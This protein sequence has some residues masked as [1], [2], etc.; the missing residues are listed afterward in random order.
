[1]ALAALVAPVALGLTGVSAGAAAQAA[2][3]EGPFDDQWCRR[4]ADLRFQDWLH[5]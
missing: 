3:A 2:G 1:M 5:L 4:T